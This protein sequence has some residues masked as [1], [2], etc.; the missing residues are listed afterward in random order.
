MLQQDEKGQLWL[1][2]VSNLQGRGEPKVQ[3]IRVLPNEMEVLAKEQA[4]DL[5]T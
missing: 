5:E 2:E 1:V 4:N 3:R